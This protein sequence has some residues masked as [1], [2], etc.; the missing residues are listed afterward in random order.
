MEEKSYTKVGK[1][2]FNILP[3]CRKQL[4]DTLSDFSDQLATKQLGI[5]WELLYM[6]I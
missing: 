3:M 2:L 5:V 6:L 4:T 1:Q